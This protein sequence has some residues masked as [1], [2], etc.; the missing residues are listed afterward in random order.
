MESRIM[1]VFY[2]ND[3]LPYKDSNRSVHYPIVGN[4][5]AGS[6]NTNE[7]RFYV[8]DIGGTDGVS[9]VVVSKLPNGKVGYEPI[10]SVATDLELGEKYISFNLSAYYTQAK[11][12]LYLTLRGYQGQ[13]DF[14]DDDED[15]IYKI[16]GDPLIEVTGAIKLSINYA[17]S[18]PCGTQ[19]LPTDVD[20]IIASLSNYTLTINSIVVLETLSQ[21]NADKYQY[22][23]V[24]YIKDIDLYYIYESGTSI[25]LYS[26]FYHQGIVV[27]QDYTDL[28]PTDFLDNQ[29][30]YSLSDNKFYIVDSG[31]YVEYDIGGIK[32]YVVSYTTKYAEKDGNN[33]FTGQNT[34]SGR[35]I[36]SGNANLHNTRLTTNSKNYF[37]RVGVTEGQYVTYNLP[38]NYNDVGEQTYTIATQEYVNNYAYPKSDVYN[39]DEINTMFSSALIYQGTK[40]VAEIN[41]LD[42][43]TL[44][45]GYFYNVSDSGIITLGNLEVLAGDNICWTGSGWDKL[46]MDLSAYDDKFI[47]AGFFEVQDYDED[48]G[49]I[50]IVY[51]SDL[52]DMSYNDN[53]GILTIEAI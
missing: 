4:S 53:T 10:S 24:F 46:T 41:A 6:N 29:I 44:K 33:T 32:S 26:A 7:I 13:I 36:F 31:N 11:G 52:Y 28:A 20:K 22:G 1:Q 16:V 27:L 19:I 30:I 51:A 47:A 18:I 40:T 25:N 23:Q 48:T 35:I 37:V 12:D 5:F 8:R 39:K 3:L 17:P 15:G 43:S 50:T 34:F 14:E 9:W 42:T 49:E 2:G 45:V 21:F 38:F